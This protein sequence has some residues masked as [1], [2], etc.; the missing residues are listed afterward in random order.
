MPGIAV[1]LGLERG[2]QQQ[3]QHPAAPDSDGLGRRCPGAAVGMMQRLAERLRRRALVDL[4]D[5]PHAR[6]PHALVP[7]AHE[8]HQLVDGGGLAQAAEQRRAVPDLVGMVAGEQRRHQRIRAGHAAEH[9]VVEPADADRLALDQ[10]VE[11][12]LGGI[13]PDPPQH[14]GRARAERRILFREVHQRLD[15]APGD[16]PPHLDAEH[17]PVARGHLGRQAHERE[18]GGEHRVPG[19]APGTP[20]ERLVQALDLRALAVD[21]VEAALAGRP[22]GRRRAA[23]RCRRN[24]R[25]RAGGAPPRPP[26]PALRISGGTEAAAPGRRRARPA[27]PAAGRGTPPSAPGRWGRTE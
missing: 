27:L 25:A 7:M 10:P 17:A 24:G 14:L 3:R 5:G 19:H 8:R 20:T 23:A 11:D 2:H 9:V 16:G 12:D 6:H 21:E 18:R 15:G 13:E 1:A 26:L 22:G 4:A